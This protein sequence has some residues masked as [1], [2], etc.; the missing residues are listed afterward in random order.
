MEKERKV[1]TL[2][3]VALIVAVLGLTV[4]FAAL[5]QTLTINGTASVNAATW[6][7]HF[8]N[9]D[10]EIQGDASFNSEPVLDGTKISNIN[11]TLTK[12][13]DMLNIEVDISNKGTINAKISSVEVSKLCT[14]SSPVEACD[15]DNDGVVTQSDIDKVENNISF[16]IG[17]IESDEVLGGTLLKQNDTLNAGKSKSIAI[18][19]SYSKFTEINGSYGDENSEVEA[20]ELPKRN[21]QFNDLSVVINYVQ[22]D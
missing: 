11:G 10:K 7:I 12:P 14:L 21:L 17:Y 4:A 3:L 2:S 19:I 22:A 16:I 18:V 15:W 20:T 5:S 13:G 6:D 8:E 1:K 9:L